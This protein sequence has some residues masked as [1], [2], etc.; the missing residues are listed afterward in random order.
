MA[1]VNW[2]QHVP[3]LYSPTGIFTLGATTAGVQTPGTYTG[4]W[5]MLCVHA[6]LAYASRSGEDLAQSSSRRIAV[7]RDHHDSTHRDT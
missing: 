1:R 2:I 4:L 7:G 6:T 3:N 5:W